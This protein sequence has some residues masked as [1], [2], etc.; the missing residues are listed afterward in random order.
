MK[1][2]YWKY[3]S[4]AELILKNWNGLIQNGFC[5]IIKGQNETKEI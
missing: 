3:V 4:L 2:N 1:H 5:E